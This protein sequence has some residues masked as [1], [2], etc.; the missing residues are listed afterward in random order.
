[1]HIAALPSWFS[2]LLSTFRLFQAFLGY[3]EC[4]FF[5]SAKHFCSI[6]ITFFPLPTIFLLCWALLTSSEHFSATLSI[7]RLFQS[8]LVYT[9]RCFGSSRQHF[10]CSAKHFST[11]L[12]TFRLFQEFFCYAK[13]VFFCSAV[14]FSALLCTA[15]HTCIAENC[16]AE[17]KNRS[18]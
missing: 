7:S 8:F 2:S 11:I 14:Y 13:W 1:M 10:F 15:R 12:S 4:F 18:E 16:L 9:E 6:L 5:C 3:A 17:P